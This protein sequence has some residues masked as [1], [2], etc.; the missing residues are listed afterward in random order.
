MKSYMK[1]YRNI[2]KEKVRKSKK[3]W[4]LENKD[5]VKKYQAKWYKKNIE[6]MRIGQ[7]RR[8]NNW[9]PWERTFNLIKIRCVQ[10]PK[11]KYYYQRGIKMLITLEELK[12][13]WFRD[14]AYEMKNPSIDRI[15]SKGDYTFDNCRYIELS[16]NLSRANKGKLRG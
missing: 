3:L 1:N 12:S 2:N 10:N 8:R 14:K 5:K 4:K 9:L 13:L 16:E 15:N 11:D 6:K 7:A